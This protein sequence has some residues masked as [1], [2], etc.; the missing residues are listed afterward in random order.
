MNDIKTTGFVVACLV[1][2]P[3]PVAAQDLGGVFRNAMEKAFRN[4]VNEVV[5]DTFRSIATVSSGLISREAIRPADASGKV[6]LYR[7]AT[8]G[9]C[10]KAASYMRTQDIPFVERDINVSATYQKEYRA[11]GGNGG[12]PLLVFGSETLH[13][14]SEAAF[15]KHYA[16]MNQGSRSAG[17]QAAPQQ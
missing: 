5:D 10:R 1:L 3:L 11:Y 13:G 6:I 7:N 8:C 2:L 17:N 15:D 9:Y 16:R 12:V 14:F 4:T